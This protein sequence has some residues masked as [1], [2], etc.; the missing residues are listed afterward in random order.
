MAL[1]AGERAVL[2]TALLRRDVEVAAGVVDADD[3]AR[4]A[5]CAAIASGSGQVATCEAVLAAWSRSDRQRRGAWYTPEVVAAAQVALVD[6]VLRQ[7]DPRGIASPDVAVLDP[8]AGTGVYL[9]AAGQR[10]LAQGRV[11]KADS[12]TGL[13]IDPAAALV[14]ER[15]LAALLG[16]SGTP[17]LRVA[18]T[19][20]VPQWSDPAVAVW[21]GN[22][23]WHR[24][25]VRTLPQGEI[26]LKQA[27]TRR[28]GGRVRYGT[29]GGPGLLR[30]FLEPALRQGAG[31]HVK[32]LYNDFTYFWCMALH[33]VLDSRTGPG[34]VALLSPAAWLQGPGFGGM[35][36]ALR[37][38]F[39]AIWVLELGGD[40]RAGA[41]G[42]QL[43][44]IRAPVALVIGLR[45]AGPQ[46]DQPAE[47]LHGRLDGDAVGLRARLAAV[48]GLSDLPWQPGAQP[49]WQ[50]T[51]QLAR[52]AG[53]QPAW[54]APFSAL[55]AS[56]IGPRLTTLFPW[57][58]SGV[59]TKR[60]WPV[61]PSPDLLV[62]RW[63]ALMA[64]PDRR[65]ALRETESWT[66][67][68]APSPLDLPPD[69]TQPLHAGL[70]LASLPVDAP[71][72]PHI[73]YAFR[74]FDR[75]WLLA[76][77]RLGDRM[78]PSLWQAHGPQQVY[79][80]S[81]L[82][83][84]AVAGMQATITCDLPDL[85]HFCGRGGRDVVPLWLD[86]A[87]THPNVQPG[88]MACLSGRMGQE[89]TATDLF[90][91]TAALLASPDA[92]VPGDASGPCVPWPPSAAVWLR[93]VALGRE[94]MQVHT[95][96]RA[97]G[98]GG[99]N[100][101][102]DAQLPRCLTPIGRELQAWPQR[103]TWADGV[104]HL[105]DGAF[106]PVSE[107]VWRLRIGP[108]RILPSWLGYR[109]RDKAG[110]HSSPLDRVRGD[111]WQQAW[112]DDLLRLLGQLQAVVALQPRQRALW[113]EVLAEGP[114]S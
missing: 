88:V 51:T 49:A 108:L 56:P 96:G 91:W 13:E 100:D 78:R 19:L 7:L 62:A 27:A 4:V 71:P 23:P 39:D 97:L 70:S 64:A 87:A 22:P 111:G 66:I 83:K 14:A 77:P 61:A 24:E 54:Q 34:V 41:V 55:S 84:P 8:A 40:G 80:T 75:Q 102:H 93:G 2:A 79:L 48:T 106:G 29:D 43:F 101:S 67:D 17:R 5:M 20:A 85:D 99:Q 74:S 32:A 73:A 94:I 92:P 57:Q 89:V 18:D 42:G 46:P 6:D 90:A 1:T 31:G 26:G 10:M 110:R 112:T 95:Q 3:R 11:P 86:R 81:V 53:A 63:Q 65:T 16:P 45:R 38:G 9:A 52:Q 76:D 37:R 98:K 50:P 30:S 69:V 82:T 36:E 109:L 12:L 15:R 114:C 103:A 21:L 113:A 25:V 47:V 35:R 107:A 68:R 33:A 59:Q 58:H 72:P 105:G 60:T 44:P 28:K 104:L